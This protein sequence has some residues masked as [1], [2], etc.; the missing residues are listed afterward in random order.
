MMHLRAGSLV[1][2]FTAFLSAT[3]IV[4][5]SV[6]RLAQES[7]YVVE[8]TALE[9]WSQWSPQHT[10]IFTYTKFK[11]SRALKGR[12]PETII[13]K[14]IGGSAEGYTQKVAGVRHWQPG[15]EAVLF[16]QPSNSADGTL[17]IT[18]LMQGN[19]LV[20]R[21]ATGEPVVSNGVPEVSTIQ[22]GSSSIGTY[23]GSKMRLQDLEAR[24]QKAVQP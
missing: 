19:F 10:L 1:L 2:L 22:P 13:V 14:Q 15:E 4:P 9:R 23:H 12:S 11:V 18:G 21:S 20:E 16:L 7:T 8:A 3:T 5:V 6:E 17:E 24:V